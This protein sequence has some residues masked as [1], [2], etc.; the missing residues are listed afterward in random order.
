VVPELGGSLAQSCATCG[1]A[2]T[3][4]A[5]CPACGRR[6]VVVVP[7]GPAVLRFEGFAP[8][9]II[10]G[11]DAATG[12]AVIK[13]SAPGAISETR[14]SKDGRVSLKVEGAGE[15]GRRG[16]PQALKPLR[17]KLQ[18]DGLV[19]TLS[20]EAARDARG[21]D[22]ILTAG[23]ERY[24]VQFVTAPGAEK[25]W[26]DASAGS[27]LTQV[28]IQGAVEWIRAALDKKVYGT[29]PA[30][31]ADTILALD[32]RHSGVLATPPILESYLSRYSSPAVEFGFASVYV[33]GPTVPY[34]AR[35]GGGTP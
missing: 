34:C 28:Q 14:L 20:R 26:Q 7:T 35:L 22:A 19:V 8:T 15:I 10:D 4:A 27:A 2:L 1:T 17:Q 30:Q 11:P 31:W 29:R 6:D 25:F 16:E 24:V 33:V 3:E 13:V 23:N 5:A 18:A 32:A 9:V 12:D 21:E